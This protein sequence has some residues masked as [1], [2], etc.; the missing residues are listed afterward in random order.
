MCHRGPEPINREGLNHWIHCPV[1][2]ME[3]IRTAAPAIIEQ[4]V[5]ETK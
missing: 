2:M 1:S 3:R 5:K 4:A